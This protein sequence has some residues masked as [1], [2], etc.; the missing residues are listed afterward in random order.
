[1]GHKISPSATPVKVECCEPL[2]PGALSLLSAVIN[3]YAVL[4]CN[5]K[6]L[7]GCSEYGWVWF[8]GADDRAGSERIEVA[9][10]VHGFERFLEGRKRIADYSQSESVALQNLEHHRHLRERSHHPV[11]GEPSVHPGGDPSGVL[12]CPQILEDE[13]VPPLPERALPIQGVYGFDRRLMHHAPENL[14]VHLRGDG[15]VGTANC[16][17]DSLVSPTRLL[18]TI[19]RE[20]AVSV[21]EDRLV[22]FPQ[23][24]TAHT[25]ASLSSEPGGAGSFPRKV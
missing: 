19:S 9:G 11:E 18:R 25:R 14:L 15:E 10:E 4:R 21:E 3:E 2:F 17:A 8:P 7:G 6:R 5:A 12:P 20:S 1:M 16:L 23:A 24:W 22:R 13:L